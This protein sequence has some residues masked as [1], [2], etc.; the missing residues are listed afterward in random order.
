[1]SNMVL[2]TYVSGLSNFCFLPIQSLT[3]K[4]IFVNCVYDF[5]LFTFIVF[6]IK[7][8]L[9][10]ASA[11]N[12]VNVF[13]QGCFPFNLKLWLTKIKCTYNLLCH[14]VQIDTRTMLCSN[15]TLN[16]IVENIIFTV[17]ELY[18]ARGRI[19]NISAE[20]KMVPDKR[21]FINNHEFLKNKL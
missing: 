4:R 19:K 11:V 2:T 9:I 21:K 15:I 17:V 13:V 12:S 8:D 16:Y 20:F 10:K 3:F 18:F 14:N 6:K 7:F 5:S 1:M